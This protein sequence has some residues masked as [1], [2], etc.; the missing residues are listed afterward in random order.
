MRLV[1]PQD[2]VEK[3][4]L[5]NGKNRYGCQP[6]SD[7]RVWTCFKPEIEEW[8]ETNMRRKSGIRL[9]EE[10]HPLPAPEIGFLGWDAVVYFKN[11]RDAVLFKM[12]WL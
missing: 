6:D 3:K 9:R 12:F 1:I 5:A 7:L 11:D 8:M 2:L 4:Y 10:L